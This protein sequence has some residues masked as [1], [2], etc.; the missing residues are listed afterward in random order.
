MSCTK[1]LQNITAW[2]SLLSFVPH[3]RAIDAMNIFTDDLDFLNYGARGAPLQ[4]SHDLSLQRQGDKDSILLYCSEVD[5]FDPLFNLL[6]ETLGND[7]IE[8]TFK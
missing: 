3:I 6:C 4:P 7:N 5:K 1:S 8:N 2:K